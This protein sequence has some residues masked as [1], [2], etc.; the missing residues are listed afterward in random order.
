MSS[1]RLE[2]VSEAVKVRA[3]EALVQAWDHLEEARV[4]QA[5]GLGEPALEALGQS[6]QVAGQCLAILFSASPEATP[7]LGLLRHLIDTDQNF[8]SC[9]RPE[10]EALWNRNF[11]PALL[12]SSSLANELDRANRVLTTL[13]EATASYHSSLKRQLRD[14]RRRSNLLLTV[15]GGLCVVLTG[16]YG[17]YSYLEP[18]RAYVTQGRAYWKSAQSPDEADLNSTGFRVEA[19]GTSHEYILRLEVP[20]TMALLRLDPVMEANAEV[21]IERIEIHRQGQTSPEVLP[22]WDS[23]YWQANGDIGL[24]TIEDGTLHFRTKGNDPSLLFS[25]LDPAFH[26]DQVEAIKV[27]MRAWFRPNFLQWLYPGST[28]SGRLPS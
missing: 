14:R 8:Q 13:L 10:L 3:F 6:L 23:D 20:V 22:S 24:V 26:H 11:S 18:T 17:W 12:E 1:S 7:Q 2:K 4:L 21:W 25:N 19:D 15:L 27:R 28:P 9:S 16:L 5:Q